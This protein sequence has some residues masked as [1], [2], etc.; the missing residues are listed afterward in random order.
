MKIC[1]WGN[2][3]GALTG[4]TDGGG[5][6]QMALIAIALAK[7][8]HEVI[9]VDYK[10]TEDFV[11]S[12]GIQ[13]FCIK[14]WNNGI[15]IIR[16]FTHRL[17]LLYASLKR[18]NADVYYCRIRDFRHIFAFW[19]AKKVKAK[20]VLG[21]A[22]D[23]DV[24]NF[25]KRLKYQYL[26][27][28]GRMWWFFSGILIEIVYPFLL[29]KS[30]I[31]LVQ[32]EGQRDILLKKN[33]VSR[34]FPN[35]IDDTEFPKVSDTIPKDFIYVGA[36]DKRKG[37]AEFYELVTKAPLQTFT[38]VGKPRDQTG[39]HYFE[40][41]K[42]IQ[43]VTLLGHL[44]T[45]ETVN[46]INNSKALISTSPMEG[47]PNTFIEAWACGKPVLSLY[48]DP[49]NIIEREKLGF[50]AK[51]NINSLLDE[52]NHGEP[53]SGLSERTKA[54]VIN[55]H[56]LNDF[57]IKELSSIFENLCEPEARL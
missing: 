50:Y 17:P 20:F 26:A 15:R 19:A 23:L 42:S 46:T 31:V 11:T 9:I 34:V 10:I 4:R 27:Y 12:D 33:I 14:G 38:V 29:R 22:S 6:K 37:F 40:K 16:T 5:E 45:Q 28:I 1:I 41:F 57:R 44:K 39:Q 21:I 54:Y 56:T 52:I 43:N 49:G 30:D 47:F 8:G 36:L 51:G 25:G 35:L 18:V 13:V 7:A 24:M 48:V 3:T 32:H 55:N 2:L 53:D